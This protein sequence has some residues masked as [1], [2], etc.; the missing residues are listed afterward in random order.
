MANS[1]RETTDLNC[2]CADT[3]DWDERWVQITDDSL[4]VE[5]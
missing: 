2:I 1:P 3:G 5:L 4:I